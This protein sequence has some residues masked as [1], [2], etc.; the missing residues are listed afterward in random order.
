MKTTFVLKKNKDEFYQKII[1]NIYNTFKTDINKQSATSWRKAL[2]DTE[3]LFLN[4]KKIISG[5][6][7]SLNIKVDKYLKLQRTTLTVAY[8]SDENIFSELVNKF[9]QSTKDETSYAIATNYLL[10]ANYLDRKNKFYVKDLENQFNAWDESSVL[11]S[12]HF[13]L[14][15]SNKFNSLPSLTK[16]LEHP[17]QKGK[18]IIYSFHRKNR[19]FPGLTIIKKPNGT[20]VKNKDGTIFSIPQLAISF[21]NLPGYISNGNTPEGI[22]S[23]VGTYISPTKTIGPTPNVLIRSPFEVSP[24]IFFHKKNKYKK[25]N[26]EDYKNLLPKSW[27][28]YFP[29]YN[30][31]Y[32]GKSGRKLIIM[33]GSTDDLDYYKQQSYY[34]M[35]PTRGCLS[36]KEIWDE[37]SG[38]CLE[39]DQAKLINAFYS[40]KKL[41]G[42]LVV[43]EIDDKNKPISIEEITKLLSK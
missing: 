43:I 29:I 14:D 41:K 3:S 16:L 32:A 31:F 40:T 24:R 19:N 37:K 30:S 33:H 42:F 18:T 28:N 12:L 35:S 20:F 36:A 6:N 8:S 34:P 38:K 11:K 17:F 27:Q 21:S 4:D 13:D 5:I 10:R 15:N 39:S 9:F 25:F 22:Y 26:K 23:I 2:N 1:S 7:K